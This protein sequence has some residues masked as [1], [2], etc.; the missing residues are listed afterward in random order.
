M[1]TISAKEFCAPIFERVVREHGYD[2]EELS[3]N[4]DSMLDILMYEACDYEEA[5]LDNVVDG[6]IAEALDNLYDEYERGREEDENPVFSREAHRD[7]GKL[8]RWLYEY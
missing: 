4:F 5:A 6:D 8:Q 7:Y 1:G 3:R 2:R